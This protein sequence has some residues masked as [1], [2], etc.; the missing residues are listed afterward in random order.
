MREG[1]SEQPIVKNRTEQSTQRAVTGKVDIH[2]SIFS[3]QPAGRRFPTVY[4]TMSARGF[5]VKT[6]AWS[7]TRTIDWYIN[8]RMYSMQMR[9]ARD[10]F[11]EELITRDHLPLVCV[12][13][14]VVML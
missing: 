3:S 13:E 7:G 10:V 9:C 2:M 1:L 14:K 8:R 4:L 11:R 6:R 12:I 5:A